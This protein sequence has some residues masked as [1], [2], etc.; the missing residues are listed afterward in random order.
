MREGLVSKAG[1]SAAIIS[2]AAFLAAAFSGGCG[3][4][5][6]EIGTVEWRLELRP[7]APLETSAAVGGTYE[8]LSVFAT[9]KDEEGLDD[10]ESLW[11][12]HAGEELAWGLTNATWTRKSE[13]ADTWF[14]AGDLIRFDYGPLPRGEYE[15]LVINAAGERV[16][17][18]FRVDA[19]APQLALPVLSFSDGAVDVVSSWPET[20]LLGFDRT[21]G[22]AASI[23]APIGKAALVS[24]LGAEAAAKTIEV[25]AYGYDPAKR[26][27]A[28][29]ARAKTR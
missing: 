1:L 26:F 27:G 17:R 5:L 18:L 22:L 19:A 12:V 7:A 24:V 9:V 11:I 14:G 20:L 10:I 13:G 29:S 4:K 8:S 16:K 21:G 6:P 25:A 3:L 23:A 15:I 2:A 28:F